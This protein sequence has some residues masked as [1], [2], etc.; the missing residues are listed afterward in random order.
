MQE[1]PA[2]AQAQA[3]LEV[4]S[5]ASAMG[6]LVMQEDKDL[7]VE[8][9]EEIV[10]VT[11]REPEESEAAEPSE[12]LEPAPAM[13]TTAQKIA[14]FYGVKQVGGE[15]IFAAR[16][17]D[18]KKVLI[19]GDFNNW[20][21]MSTPMINRGQPGEFWMCLPLRP[22]RYRYRFVVDGKWM[23]DPH[24]NYVETNQFGELNNVIEVD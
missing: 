11:V 18:A 4:E 21:L 24:N 20:S 16:F 22:G 2:Q 12:A 15:V 7:Q 13:K 3:S 17:S 9:A 14:E 23:T 19:A 5:S 6:V 8:V 10:E 1:K